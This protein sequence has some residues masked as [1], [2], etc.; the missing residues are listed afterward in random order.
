MLQMNGL[1]KKTRMDFARPSLDFDGPCLDFGWPCQGDGLAIEGEWLRKATEVVGFVGLEGNGVF[2]TQTFKREGG[3][4]EGRQKWSACVRLGSHICRKI[5]KSGFAEEC[6][7]KA[8]DPPWSKALWRKRVR[9]DEKDKR[10]GWDEMAGQGAP[11]AIRRKSRRK[12]A[13]MGQVESLCASL[14]IFAQ[15][16]AASRQKSFFSEE[17]RARMGV[18]PAKTRCRSLW[19]ALA[20]V[21]SAF[22][23]GHAAIAVQSPAGW[24]AGGRFDAGARRTAHEGVCAPRKHCGREGERRIASRILILVAKIRP[25]LA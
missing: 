12:V 19:L 17:R 24:P 8:P 13:G 2:R 10:D 15:L 23:C 22:L 21:G 9:K 4:D 25:L 14:R 7:G 11:C 6:S 1:C 20:R 18:C 5:K 3:G 16:N